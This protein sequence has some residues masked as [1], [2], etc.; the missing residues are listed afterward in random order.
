MGDY[1]NRAVFEAPRDRRLS[2]VCKL[3][4]WEG[5]VCVESAAHKCLD[6]PIRPQR[7]RGQALLGVWEVGNGKRTGP[8]LLVTLPQEPVGLGAKTCARP[9]SGPA[10]GRF[11]WR[12]TL[13]ARQA[14]AKRVEEKRRRV[15]STTEHGPRSPQAMSTIKCQIRLAIGLGG[16]TGGGGSKDAG[17][18]PLKAPANRR[19]GCSSGRRRLA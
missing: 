15:L 5:G 10:L 12:A 18:T 6:A 14:S 8:R 7:E 11:L 1:T 19:P 2:P 3:A 4:S 16:A 17:G 9:G 13:A